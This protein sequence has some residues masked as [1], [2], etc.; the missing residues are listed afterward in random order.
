MR[1]AIRFGLMIAM[2]LSVTSA[3]AQ[4]LSKLQGTYKLVSGERGDMQVPKNHL[5]GI[6]RI[7]PDTMTLYDKDHNEVYVMRYSIE[8]EK[9][10]Y[11]ITMTVTKSTRRE[12]VGSKARGLIR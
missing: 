4:E 5:D 9:M 6:V 7:M 10:P 12:S 3:R 8:G 11:R 1:R 2:V